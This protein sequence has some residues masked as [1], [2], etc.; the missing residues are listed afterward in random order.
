MA[1]TLN[2]VGE[3]H[4]RLGNRTQA[5]KA[6]EK[7]LELATRIKA[8]DWERTAWRSL[9]EFYKGLSRYKE[10]LEAHQKFVA[11]NDSIHGMEKNKEIVR[12]EMRFDFMK[13]QLADSIGNAEERF[14][15]ELAHTKEMSAEKA[16]KQ[17]YI[18][19]AGGI[20]LLALGLWSRLH[21]TQKAK[22]AVEDERAISEGLLLNILPAEVATELKIKGEA[23]ARMIEEATVLFTDFKGFTEMSEKLGPKDL[24]KDIHECFS[25]FDRIMDKYGVEKIKTIGDAYMAAG[26][27]PVPRASHAEDVV[28][29]ALEIRDFIQ[30]GKE[31]KIQKGLPFFE[32][33]IGIHTG[34][35]VAGI[36]GL[37][38]FQYDIWGDTV[39]TASRMESSGEEGKV[40][41][42]E[43][44]YSKLKSNPNLS[45]SQRGKIQVKGKGE[46]EMFFVERADTAL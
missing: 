32:I 38:K 33:R 1:G 19:G 8:T 36:V 28:L 9:S 24:I 30:Q 12:K 40:N 10:A 11:L 34:P 21:F 23:E 22:K 25:A 42:S 29:A 43:V 16:R 4:W 26:G 7:S 17:L 20:L 35:I 6:S 14:Q 37:K 41:I 13:Q 27:V 45:F 18:F 31:L 46:L 3:A 44:T 2:N 15:V 39:N 5:L